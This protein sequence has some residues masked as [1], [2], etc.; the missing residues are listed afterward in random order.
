MHMNT[1]MQTTKQIQPWQA[2]DG[3]L[4]GSKGADADPLQRWTE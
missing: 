4:P 1:Y 3:R 2:F